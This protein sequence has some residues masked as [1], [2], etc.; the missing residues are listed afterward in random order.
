MGLYKRGGKYFAA[1]E[2]F[3]RKGYSY[4]EEDTDSPLEKREAEISEEKAMEAL[5]ILKELVKSRKGVKRPTDAMPAM[6]LDGTIVEF[7]FKS[8][9]STVFFQWWMALPKGYD[10]LDD[11]HSVIDDCIPA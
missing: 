5:G 11:L 7:K 2:F 3:K 4:D 6:G 9:S 8:G 1:H 10:L